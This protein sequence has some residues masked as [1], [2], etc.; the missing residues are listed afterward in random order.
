MKSS[1]KRTVLFSVN[2][3]IITVDNAAKI[4][5]PDH[6]LYFLDV[7]QNKNKQIKKK[8]LNNCTDL[9]DLKKK[10]RYLNFN[11]MNES[12]KKCK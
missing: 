11:K 2:E 7:L 6:K 5:S 3:E 10:K 1:C 9:S 12:L 4:F 8:W